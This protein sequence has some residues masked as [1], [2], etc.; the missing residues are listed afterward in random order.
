MI[1]GAAQV[2]AASRVDP[3]SIARRIG[4]NAVF[5]LQ[6]L[7]NSFFFFLFIYLFI[8]ITERARRR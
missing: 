6:V 1:A 4:V 5:V 2:D 3:V 8:H 7:R